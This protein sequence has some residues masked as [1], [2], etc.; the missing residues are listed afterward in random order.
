MITPPELLSSAPPHPGA[1]LFPAPAPSG[2]A[3]RCQIKGAGAGGS[4]VLTNTGGALWQLKSNRQD[5]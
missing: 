4:L 1:L 5:R 2:S 3:R